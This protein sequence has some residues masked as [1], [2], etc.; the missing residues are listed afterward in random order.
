MNRQKEYTDLMLELENTPD[1][2]VQLSKKTKPRAKRRNVMKCVLTPP[3]VLMA[4]I[5]MLTVAVNTS[6]TVARAVEQISLLRHVALIVNFNQTLTDAIEHDFVQRINLEQTK[7]DIT[8]RVEYVIVDQRQLNIFYT[9]RSPIH[10]HLSCYQPNILNADN[11]EYLAVGAGWSSG[12]GWGGEHHDNPIRHVTVDFFDEIMP[13]TLIFELYVQII[14]PSHLPVQPMI[15]PVLTELEDPISFSFVLEFDPTL[16]GESEILHV[17]KDF[18]VDGQRFTLD[19]VEIYPLHMRVDF[20]A[21]STNTAWLRSLIFHAEDGQ[22]NR[23]DV[24]SSG[25]VSIGYAYSPMAV[26]HFLNSPFFA[27]SNELTIF[28]NGVRLLDKDHLVRIDLANGEAERLPQGITFDGAYWDGQSWH[29]SFS[30]E[31]RGEGMFHT[32]FDSAYFNE[33][34]D[35]FCLSNSWDVPFQGVTDIFNPYTFPTQYVLGNFPYDVVYLSPSY[36][37]TV[38]LNEPIALIVR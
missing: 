15:L 24:A 32:P 14:D 28:I 33:A 18:V 36:S 20:S 23:F 11:M 1:T 34:G 10:P 16:F 25:T 30:V 29:V 38:E 9:L 7:D 12:I 4:M 21:D 8:M 2:M 26:S 35:E 13:D 5:L 3:S 17:D 37:R 27:E 31:K 22:G 6:P 19:A